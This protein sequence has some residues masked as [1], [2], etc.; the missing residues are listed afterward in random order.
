MEL[1]LAM[2]A[3]QVASVDTRVMLY[4]AAG[5]WQIL[6]CLVLHRPLT[7]ECVKIILNKLSNFRIFLRDYHHN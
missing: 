6:R 2:V 5:T 1:I 7:T 4:T 3:A